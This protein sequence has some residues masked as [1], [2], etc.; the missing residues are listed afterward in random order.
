MHGVEFF[1]KFTSDVGSGQGV[2]RVAEE[3]SSPGQWRFFMLS[4]TLFELAGH[5]RPIDHFRPKGVEHGGD[6]NRQNWKD[7]RASEI[8]FEN[9]QPQVVIVGR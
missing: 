3:S 1:I 2:A 7:R 5:E 4:T 9:T 6:P 8:N